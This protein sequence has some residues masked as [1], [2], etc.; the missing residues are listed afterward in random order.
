[1]AMSEQKSAFSL[2]I[3][4]HARVEETFAVNERPIVSLLTLIM[5]REIEDCWDLL[6]RKHM[7]PVGLRP[8]LASIKDAK[9]MGW[10][11]PP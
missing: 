11:V 1:M 9:F 4:S 10:P 5:L 6:G 7:G 8:K 2:R 3:G